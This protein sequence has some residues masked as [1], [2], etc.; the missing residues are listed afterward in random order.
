MPCVAAA[1]N[2]AAVLRHPLHA[3]PGVGVGVLEARHDVARDQLVAPARGLAVR[4]V[5]RGDEEGAEA[6]RL[7]LEPLDLRDQVVGRA[8]DDEADV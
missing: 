4:P 7:L 2:G 6:A 3:A 1:R 5:V 8:D